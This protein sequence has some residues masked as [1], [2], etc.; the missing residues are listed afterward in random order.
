VSPKFARQ[1][2]NCVLVSKKIWDYREGETHDNEQN[3]PNPQNKGTKRC[4]LFPKTKYAR[5]T[6]PKTTPKI[7]DPSLLTEGRF[8]RAISHEIR[9]NDDGLRVFHLAAVKIEPA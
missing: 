3:Q 8:P 7:S 5:P 6:A 9:S 1:V 2:I 4:C